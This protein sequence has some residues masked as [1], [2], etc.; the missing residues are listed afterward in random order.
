MRLDSSSLVV[1][2]FFLL[3]L[4]V[5]VINTPKVT[6]SDEVSHQHQSDKHKI[7]CVSTVLTHNTSRMG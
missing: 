2:L 7:G 6:V 1:C 5:V 3:F 4:A